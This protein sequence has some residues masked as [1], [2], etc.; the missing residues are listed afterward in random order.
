MPGFF[1]YLCSNT[2]TMIGFELELSS[3][4]FW[5]IGIDTYVEIDESNEQCFSV[6]SI[7]LLFISFNI[8]VE[9]NDCDQF[10]D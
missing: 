6:F 10:Y 3:L 8:L 9:R 1:Y 7:G 4:D 5:K 2:T